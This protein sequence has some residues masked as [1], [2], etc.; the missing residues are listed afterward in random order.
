MMQKGKR[1][2]KSDEDY[3]LRKEQ[4]SYIADLEHKQVALNMITIIMER[5]YKWFQNHP[6]G[7]ISTLD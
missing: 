1:V 4:A 3:Y 5:F 6:S 2:A 7:S